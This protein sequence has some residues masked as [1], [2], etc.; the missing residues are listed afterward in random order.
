[1]YKNIMRWLQNYSCCN[2]IFS[3]ME[4]KNSTTRLPLFFK[5]LMW[6]YRFDS[7]NPETMEE[8]TVVQ[9]INYGNWRHWQWISG[10]YGKDKIRKI[11]ENLSASEF[12]P[13]VL[14]LASLIFGIKK[15]KYANRS[16]KIRAAK[17]S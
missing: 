8:I 2:F 13:S 6:S 11:I 16:D 9:T 5:P 3:S 1:M 12:R 10:F 7:I 17:N 15:M 14:A 4:V